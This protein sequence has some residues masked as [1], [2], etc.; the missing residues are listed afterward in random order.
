GRHHTGDEEYQP[1]ETEA[2]QNEQRPQ[3]FGQWSE[4]KLRPDIPSDDDSP[5]DEAEYDA[6]EKAEL[7]KHERLLVQVCCVRTELCRHAAVVRGTGLVATRPRGLGGLG[8]DVLAPPDPGLGRE[9]RLRGKRAAQ[10]AVVA[11]EIEARAERGR[12]EL[13]ELAKPIADCRL[14][15]RQGR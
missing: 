9:L 10:F 3:G 14:V 11:F 5:R 15:A 8:D 6:S 1:D 13:R 12:Q 4:A 2:V 7:R